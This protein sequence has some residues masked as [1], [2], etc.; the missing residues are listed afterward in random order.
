M[1]VYAFNSSIH[2]YEFQ[3]LFRFVVLLLLLYLF[4]FLASATLSLSLLFSSLCFFSC[5]SHL[6]N[7]FSE[8]KI[9]IIFRFQIENRAIHLFCFLF[10]V[11]VFIYFIHFWGCVCSHSNVRRFLSSLFDFFFSSHLRPVFCA[12]VRSFAS[13]IVSVQSRVSFFS[14]KWKISKSD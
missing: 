12:F 3:N 2:I 5:L 1:C 8:C 14:S 10:F 4:C 11:F 6:Q 7:A 9:N 13:R